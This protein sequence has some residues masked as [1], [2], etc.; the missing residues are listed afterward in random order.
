MRTRNADTRQFKWKW[1]SMNDATQWNRLNYDIFGIVW[2]LLLYFLLYGLST[3]FHFERIKIK[4]C[5]Y[6][7]IIIVSLSRALWQTCALYN[8]N[9]KRSQNWNWNW[10]TSIFGIRFLMSILMCIERFKNV[11]MA[12]ELFA[13]RQHRYRQLSSRKYENKEMSLHSA[14]AFDFLSMLTSRHKTKIIP[15]S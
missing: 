4:Q 2:F 9:V 1:N 6:D 7:F 14:I 13:H 15:S 11:K 8:S 3:R 5:H 12:Y 10:I